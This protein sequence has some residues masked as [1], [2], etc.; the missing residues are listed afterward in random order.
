[1]SRLIE[2]STW[3]GLGVVIGTLS[4]YL[5]APWSLAAGAVA[6]G[7]GA[8]AVWLRERGSRPPVA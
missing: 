8:G 2:P 3:A 5:P 7:L 6:A 1:M 4:G